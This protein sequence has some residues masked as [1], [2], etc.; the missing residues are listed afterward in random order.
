MGKMEIEMTSPVTTIDDRF[1]A[2]DAVATTWEETQRVIESA[3]LF[4]LTTVRTDGRPH[5][6]PLVAVWSGG[7]LH[8]TTGD[9]EQKSVNL[10]SNAHVLLS[11]GCNGWEEGLD[12]VV[13]GVALRATDQAV[14]ERISQ[15]WLSKWDG[16]WEYTAREGKF[17][18]SQGFEV[19]AYSVVP[20]KVL[21][22]AKGKFGQTVHR[23]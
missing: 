15:A 9:Q 18:H 14:L 2:S 20:E 6:T 10:K 22:F 1:G 12:V 21:V 4:W 19:E 5:C 17:Y 16:S 11:T 7:A 8:F 13:E 3:E 23:F